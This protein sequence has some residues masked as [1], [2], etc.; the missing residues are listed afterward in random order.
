M[1]E[2]ENEQKQIEF[3]ANSGG[4]F[5]FKM[6]LK[7]RSRSPRPWVQK[8]Q[9]DPEYRLCI[10][11]WNLVFAMGLISGGFVLIHFAVTEFV[12]QEKNMICKA[13]IIVIQKARKIL[14]SCGTHSNVL[15]LFALYNIALLASDVAGTREGLHLYV[16]LYDVMRW[17]WW[18][19]ITCRYT[20]N[21]NHW[22]VC[23]DVVLLET[24]WGH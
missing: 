8:G 6:T 15:V 20:L 21:W 12:L 17:L 23:F 22:L 18:I 5:L 4:H 2:K 9:P 7:Y 19:I 1:V 24:K 14:F 16:C 3:F 10:V 11:L 13:F